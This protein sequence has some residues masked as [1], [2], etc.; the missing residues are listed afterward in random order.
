MNGMNQ[1]VPIGTEAPMYKY[2]LI[3]MVRIWNRLVKTVPSRNQ[4]DGSRYNYLKQ[5]FGCAHDERSDEISPAFTL[6]A[7]FIPLA[8]SQLAKNLKLS[9]LGLKR[10]VE[11]RHHPNGNR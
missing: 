9:I 6:R 3:L 10:F 5:N 4:N 8:K 2:R 1:I 7:T 11:R